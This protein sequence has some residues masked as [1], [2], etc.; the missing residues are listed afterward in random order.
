MPVN[1]VKEFKSFMMNQEIV[2]EMQ[3]DRE[4]TIY[5]KSKEQKRDVYFYVMHKFADQRQLEI[6]YD[7]SQM[8]IESNE[9]RK[10]AL[11][12]IEGFARDFHSFIEIDHGNE[13]KIFYRTEGTR[14]VIARFVKKYYDRKFFLD[15]SATASDFL[16]ITFKA[17]Y[18]DG[19]ALSEDVY[20]YFTKKLTA[21]A[22]S[23]HSEI[24]FVSINEIV[25]TSPT[26]KIR[27]SL[28][29]RFRDYEN[30][31][32]YRDNGTTNYLRITY[33]LSASEATG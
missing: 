23:Y 25:V 13:V 27:Q 17:L 9:S 10:M 6:H 26:E 14:R 15:E 31:K 7:Y 24:S 18:V 32:V 28:K 22:E 19:M 20:E 21:I 29:M 8:S 16:H 30:V 3:S 1:L 4:I 33:V 2:F 11:E 12:E 5:P